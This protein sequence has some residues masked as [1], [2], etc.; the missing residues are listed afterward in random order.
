MHPQKVKHTRRSDLAP[1]MWVTSEGPCGLCPIRLL[2]WEWPLQ[3]GI[4]PGAQ[5]HAG[6]PDN[7][8]SRSYHLL[9][10]RTTTGLVPTSPAEPQFSQRQNDPGNGRRLSTPGDAPGAALPP[11]PMDALWTFAFYGIWPWAVS[12]QCR[13]LQRSPCTPQRR[14]AGISAL[15]WAVVPRFLP[16]AEVREAQLTANSRRAIPPEVPRLLPPLSRPWSATR[17]SLVSLVRP[18]PPRRLLLCSV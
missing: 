5:C 3:R 7:G 11:L 2:E 13:R 16:L 1:A 15:S 8:L 6:M 17:L 12:A 14:A 18:L 10:V 4:S 9:S